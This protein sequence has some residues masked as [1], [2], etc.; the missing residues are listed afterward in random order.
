MKLPE[1]IKISCLNDFAYCECKIW[2]L[3]FGAGD[4]DTQD[5][6]DGREK[7]T[8]N[9]E[10]YTIPIS[11]EKAKSNLKEGKSTCSDEYPVVSDKLKL[12][13]RIDRLE[14]FNDKVIIWDLKPRK[15]NN[16]IYPSTIYQLVG[17]YLALTYKRPSIFT[18]IYDN[19]TNKD[20]FIGVKDEI[21]NE[22]LM[23][24]TFPKLEWISRV[25]DAIDK[26]NK[27]F[28]KEISPKLNDNPNKCRS[29]SKY[30]DT[31]PWAIK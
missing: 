25:Y 18:G 5:C 30:Y 21:T 22:I 9:S 1:Y 11:L 23:H 2:N 19:F 3:F 28:K 27:I 24:P 20:I 4:V 7:H 10:K 16:I 13:G 31:C 17:Y 12:R 14:I 15:R 8:A 6:K 29:C 26:I